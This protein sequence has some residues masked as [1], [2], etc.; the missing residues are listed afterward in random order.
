MEDILID[1]NFDLSVS[2][3]GDFK[4]GNSDY[5]HQSLLLLLH[6]GEIKQFPKA[7]AGIAD[8]LLDDAHSEMLREARMQFEQDGMDVQQIVFE[9]GKMYWNAAYN[10]G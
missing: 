5:Q 2:E 1:N 7:G 6:K 4:T 8:Y 10:Q 9:E 3:D